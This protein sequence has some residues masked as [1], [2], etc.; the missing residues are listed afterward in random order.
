RYNTIRW[1][2]TVDGFFALGPS[3]VNPLTGEILDAD[4][5]VDASFV[6]SLKQ[7]YR[8]LVQENRAQPT[9]MLS[10]LIQQR[11]LCGN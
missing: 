4:I 8:L 10:Q 7:Q 11:N 5:L 6:R 9:S 1:I 2:N 3:R